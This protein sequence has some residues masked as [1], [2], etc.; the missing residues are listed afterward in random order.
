MPFTR[1]L[2]IAHRGESFDAPENTLTAFNLAW[3]RGVEAIELD[4]HLTADGHVVV[5][6]D[7]NTQRTGGN[8][9]VI[10]NSTLQTLQSLDVGKWKA[11]RYEGERIATLDDVIGQVPPGRQA[12]VE[13]KSGLETVGPVAA[14]LDRHPAD[15]T[16]IAFDVEV[17]RAMKRRNPHRRVLWLVSPKRDTTTGEWSITSPEILRIAHDAGADGVDINQRYDITPALVD[18]AH[19]GGMAFVIW[20]VDDVARA[21]HLAELGVDGITSNRAAWL[22]DQM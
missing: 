5:C 16:V 21:R 10:A 13:I 14:V 22:R 4:V 3:E 6:H 1:T 20:T 7:P 19:A 2:L 11:D 15:V 17:V 8:N 12:Y 18:A 9:S